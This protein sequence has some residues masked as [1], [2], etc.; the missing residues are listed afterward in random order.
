MPGDVITRVHNLACRSRAALGLEFTDRH[1]EPY[2]DDNGLGDDPD[3]DDDMYDPA[4]D[5][6]LDDGDDDDSDDDRSAASDTDDSNYDEEGDDDDDDDADDNYHNFPTIA[7]VDEGQNDRND[8]DDPDADN[9]DAPIDGNRANGHDGMDEDEHGSEPDGS[10]VK[11]QDI[12]DPDMEPALRRELKKL[13][14]EGLA[15]PLQPGRTQQQTRNSGVNN[16]TDGHWR[17]KGDIT[18]SLMGVQQAGVAK[19][20]DYAHHHPVLKSTVMTQHT[21][22]KGLKLFGEARVD[23]VLAELQ[24]LHDRKVMEPVD[25]G[26][27]SYEQ[28]K[29]SLEYLMFLKK[30]R[31]GKIKGRGCADGQKQREHT[32]KD[33]ASAPTVA[34]ESVMLSCVIDA[35]EER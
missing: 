16:A 28:H 14:N 30:K 1:G 29:A 5:D 33:A 34:I 32:A 20:Q 35:K 12:D 21:M 10:E 31:S 24:Q 3:S 11:G 27:M 6:T 22:K 17:I 18:Q 9:N 13:L 7:G 4:D 23:A 8:Q 26:G 15:P 25:Q 19:P 2:P